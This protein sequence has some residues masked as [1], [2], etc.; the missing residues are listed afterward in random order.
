MDYYCSMGIVLNFS[1]LCYETFGFPKGNRIFRKIHLKNLI[2]NWF[3]RI[4]CLEG[5]LAV[6]TEL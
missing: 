1:N 2:A 4:F 3:L 5:K 6:Y